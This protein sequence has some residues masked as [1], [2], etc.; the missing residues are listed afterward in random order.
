MEEWREAPQFPEY[1]V[2]NMGQVRR[3]VTGSINPGSVVKQQIGRAGYFCVYL[4]PTPRIG[5]TRRI[6]KNVHLLVLKAFKGNPPPDHEANHKNGKK[7][8]P[9]LGNLEWV[10]SSENKKH[11]Y[12]T[13]L[14]KPTRH[15]KEGEVWLIR[16]L[17][18]SKKVSQEIIAK[19]F[20]IH[21]VTV[22]E[23]KL[24]KIWR[25]VSFDK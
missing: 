10:T 25:E 1:E 2:S 24:Q 20:K 17:L 9:S 11:A 8:D 7:T 21:Q 16:K 13:G 22:S 3:S 15:L 6:C 23:I 5:G 19:M 12:A 18:A 14:R 4:F